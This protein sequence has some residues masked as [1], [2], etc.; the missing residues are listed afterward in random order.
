G[1][2]YV[3]LIR[4]HSRTLLPGEDVSAPGVLDVT[5]YPDVSELFLVAD[6]LVTDYS[7][8]MFDFSVTEKPIF[9]FTPDFEAYRD[10]LR[11]FYFDLLPVAPGPVSTTIDE[12][13]AQVLERQSV[14]ED[15]AERYDAWRQRFNPR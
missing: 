3:T 6:L 4:G 12:L 15:Y 8:V 7:S 5:G 14:T 1:D 9:F 2:K 10:Q 13:L 11:G